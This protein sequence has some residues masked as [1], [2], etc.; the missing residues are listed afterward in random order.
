M[1]GSTIESPAPQT[2]LNTVSWWAAL[3]KPIRR[4]LARIKHQRR[5]RRDIDSLVEFDDHMLADFGLRRVD[6]EYAAWHGR[7]PDRRHDSLRR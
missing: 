1:N 2:G 7:L 5:I 6:I 4:Q 3:V